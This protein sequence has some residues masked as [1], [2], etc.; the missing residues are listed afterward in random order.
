MDQ[1]LDS[2][3][4]KNFLFVW[5]CFL[6]IFSFLSW[7][8]NNLVLNLWNCSYNFLTLSVSLLIFFG[9][10]GRSAFWKSSSTL[11]L[12]LQP[13]LV[14][15]IKIL[16]FWDFPGGTVV[17]NPPANAWGTGSIPSL[18]K[19]H[20]PWSPCVTTTG[21]H[22]PRAHAPQQEKPPQWEARALQRRVAP[23]HCN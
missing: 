6:P 18:G 2:V 23:A 21:A 16:N 12:N 8:L 11:S 22:A 19:S 7:A 5:F 20:V 14:F 1:S 17:K 13:F 15:V 10:E 9:G 3:I 4:F